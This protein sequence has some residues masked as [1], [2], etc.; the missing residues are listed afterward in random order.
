MENPQ[1]GALLAAIL[2]LISSV[3]VGSWVHD[4]QLAGLVLVGAFVAVLGGLLLA[5]AFSRQ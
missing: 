2:A 1:F 4:W 5:R 3:V